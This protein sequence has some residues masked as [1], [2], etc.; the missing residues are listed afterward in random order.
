MGLSVT[1]NQHE[2][3]NG[4]DR[5]NGVNG[6]DAKANEV[7]LTTAELQS[8]AFTDIPMPTENGGYSHTSSSKAKISAANKGKTPW[9]KGRERSPE[10]RARISAGVR[11]RNHERHLKKLAELGLTEEEWIAKKKEERRKKDAE[12]RARRTKNGGYRPTDATKQKISKILKAKWAAGEVKMTKR[13]PAKARR[14]FTHTAETRA[15]ISESLRKRW[16]NDDDYR[17]SMKNKT[18]VNNSSEETRKKISETLK[19]KWQDPEFREKMMAKMKTRKSP[20]GERDQSYRDKVSAAMKAKWQDPEYRAKTLSKIRA[21][22]EEIRKSRPP[23][24]KKVVVRKKKKKVVKASGRSANGSGTAGSNRGGI[25]RVEPASEARPRKRRGVKKTPK[26]DQDGNPI[27]QRRAARKKTKAIGEGATTDISASAASVARVA[28]SRRKQAEQLPGAGDT[29]LDITSGQEEGTETKKKKRKS[30]KRQPAS[31]NES[32]DQLRDENRGL[33]DLLYGDEEDGDDGDTDLDMDFGVIDDDIE[34]RE[35]EA[36]RSGSG[37]T[38]VPGISSTLF[39]DDDDL[40][41]FDPYG[42]DDY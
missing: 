24:P 22:S 18:I 28:A 42:L 32:I 16:A 41:D 9:N 33:Y 19:Q 39:A 40:D 1:L 36:V 8:G 25:A 17:E 35:M 13:D 29:D 20:S 5:P 11:A 38:T 14:G 21:R 34:E 15:K 27:V 2:Q 12:R 30:N 3:S 10:E 4:V 6:V 37:S 31:M 23:K 26:F 7:T